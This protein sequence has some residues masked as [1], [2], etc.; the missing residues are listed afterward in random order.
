[1]KQ[2]SRE[3]TP[4][5][6]RADWNTRLSE[7]R[8]SIAWNII[9]SLNWTCRGTRTE[10]TGVK[11][12]CASGTDS[13]SVG[14]VQVTGVRSDFWDL[15]EALQ[16]GKKCCQKWGSVRL[17]RGR[18]HRTTHQRRRSSCQPPCQKIPFICHPPYWRK[19]CQV[20]PENLH[21]KGSQGALWILFFFLWY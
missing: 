5:I 14:T 6:D 8:C 7:H 18:A 13:A 12:L 11:M 1:M 21:T 15:K 20:Q 17:A 3:I 2:P 19:G 4:V 9:L 10:C 16:R